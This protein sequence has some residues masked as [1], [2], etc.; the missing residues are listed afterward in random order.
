MKDNT[1]SE[2]AQGIG[3]RTKLL[4]TRGV[5]TDEKMRLHSELRRHRTPGWGS[6]RTVLDRITY[7][8]DRDER[9]FRHQAEENVFSLIGIAGQLLPVCSTMPYL[10]SLQYPWSNAKG[11]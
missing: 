11:Q 9:F 1:S 7:G 4:V 6:S 3:C 2:G 10:G 5:T 8:P